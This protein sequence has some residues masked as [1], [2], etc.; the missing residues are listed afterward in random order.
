MAEYLS[1]AQFAEKHE[2][3]RSNVLRMIAAGRIEATKI[4]NQWCIPAD[5]PRP[6]DLRVKS[7]KYRDWGRYR[8][9]AGVNKT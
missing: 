1:A 9:S 5:A 2:M 8:K 3:Q 7:G 4:G 6:D